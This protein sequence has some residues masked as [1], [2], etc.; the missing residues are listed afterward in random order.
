MRKLMTK[1]SYEAAM[2]FALVACV[3]TVAAAW[4]HAFGHMGQ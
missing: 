1:I 4:L 2:V 3:A